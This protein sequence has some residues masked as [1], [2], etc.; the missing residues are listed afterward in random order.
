[1]EV[2]TDTFSAISAESEMLRKHAERAAPGRHRRPR[3]QRQPGE[4]LTPD[5]PLDGYWRAGYSVAMSEI[6][7]AMS[8]AVDTA[9]AHADATIDQTRRAAAEAALA[10]ASAAVELYHRDTIPPSWLDS[11]C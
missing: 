11:Q 7:R 10:V 9:D 5:R 4:H 2:D 8:D 6:L 3:R 1:M